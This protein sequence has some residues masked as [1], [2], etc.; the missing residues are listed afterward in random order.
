MAFA[1]MGKRLG[2][3]HLPDSRLNIFHAF[4]LE[5]VK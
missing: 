3:I 2:R 4:L 1:V 5:R